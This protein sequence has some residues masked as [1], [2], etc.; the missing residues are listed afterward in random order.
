ML[1]I[2]PRMSGATRESTRRSTSVSLARA[3]GAQ[4]GTCIVSDTHG[5]AVISASLLLAAFSAAVLSEFT[6]DDG[7][8]ATARV[9]VALIYGPQGGGTHG[10]L[11]VRRRPGGVGLLRETDHRVVLALL[12]SALALKR[13]VGDGTCGAPGSLSRACRAGLQGM[14]TALFRRASQG[15][16]RRRHISL[17]AASFGFSHPI[18]DHG[19]VRPAK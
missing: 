1:A 15:V 12:V 3:D 2:Q 17:C 10:A 11:G 9:L 13:I 8:A 5:H 4:D 7:H 18:D 6:G 14:G 19:V 16:P